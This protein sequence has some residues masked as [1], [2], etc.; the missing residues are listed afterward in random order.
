MMPY[1]ERWRKCRRMLHAHVHYG[2]VPRYEGTVERRVRE[3]AQG[4]MKDPS[5]LPERVRESFGGTIMKL[6]YGY[7]ITGK[8]DPYIGAAEGVL[9]YLNLAGIPGRYLVDIFSPC[10]WNVIRFQSLL[11]KLLAVKYVPSWFPGAGFQKDAELTR[12]LHVK[13]RNDPMEYVKK[14]IVRCHLG[15]EYPAT[16]SP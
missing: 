11:I 8:D 2:M 13:A 16:Y 9:H 4:L 15:L 1:G 12:R 3:F 6:L 7:D 10:E 5:H 14:T